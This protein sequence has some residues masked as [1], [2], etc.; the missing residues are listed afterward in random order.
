MPCVGEGGQ[1]RC[2]VTGTEI[3]GL[4]SARQGGRSICANTRRAEPRSPGFLGKADLTG[5]Q[6]ALW[7][8]ALGGCISAAENLTGGSRPALLS[9]GQRTEPPKRGESDVPPVDAA[10]V[11][12][13]R[14]DTAKGAGRV[15]LVRKEELLVGLFF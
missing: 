13:D 10:T 5:P 7:M 4:R 3:K 2:K 9:S 14:E 15:L 1:S 8:V 12:L 6:E 11:V